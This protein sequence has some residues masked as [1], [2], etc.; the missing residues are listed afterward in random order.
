M[1]WEAND[2]GHQGEWQA[3][4]E[5]LLQPTVKLTSVTDLEFDTSNMSYYGTGKVSRVYQGCWVQVAFPSM[6][7][8]ETVKLSENARGG[9]WASANSYE[10]SPTQQ[11]E[12]GGRATRRRWL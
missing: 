9:F 12:R 4:M 3:L 11:G 6:L 1:A 8:G 2:E 5:I 7:A 10:Q